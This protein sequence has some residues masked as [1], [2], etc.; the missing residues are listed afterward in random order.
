[1]KHALLAVPVLAAG[2]LVYIAAGASS[3]PPGLA[4][5]DGDRSGSASPTLRRVW[6]A[7]PWRT[8][9]MGTVS[10]DGRLLSFTDWNTGDV[11]VYDVENGE[12]AL[13]TG[14]PFVNGAGGF[15]EYS[16]VSRDG[17]QIAY[18]WYAGTEE[19]DEST[20]ELRIIPSDGSAPPRTVVAH[21]WLR[22]H[23]WSPDG[24]VV[25]AELSQPGRTSQIALVSV[26][27]GSVRRLRSLAWG[28]ATR[29]SFSPDGRYLAYAPVDP[30]GRSRTIYTLSIDASEEVPVV[31]GPDNATIAPR[32]SA[33][34]DYLI[35]WVPDGQALL[36]GSARAGTPGIWSVPVHK[37]RPT[38]DPR[39][40]RSDVWAAS[41]LGVTRDAEVFLATESSQ[42]GLFVADIEP[43]T[44]TLAGEPVRVQT[45]RRP[46]AKPPAWSRDGRSLAFIAAD[47][48]SLEIVHASTGEL[49]E[50]ASGLQ[51]VG[52]VTWLPDGMTLGLKG[53]DDSGRSGWFRL[54]PQTGILSPIAYQ[55]SYFENWSA[56]GKVVYYHHR[57]CLGASESESFFGV[58]AR[59][60][61]SGVDD[62]LWTASEPIPNGMLAGLDLSP[63]GRQLAVVGRNGGPVGLLS[64][65]GGPIRVLYRAG[66]D[67]KLRTA[68][69]AP[70]GEYL[71]LTVETQEG[72]G[73]WRLPAE[74]G[75]PELVEI[76]ENGLSQVAIHPTG[77][78]IAFTSGT[79]YQ[80]VWMLSLGGSEEGR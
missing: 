80:E 26:D 30:D 46:R 52:A 29:I 59:D 67:M 20:Y 38:G 2:W 11:G 56:D 41:G 10:S 61:A 37:G 18:S 9:S 36:F 22:P 76:I 15:A 72:K 34:E 44:G 51:Y 48:F 27:D 24:R 53:E 66:P 47:R 79:E 5:L 28:G 55:H 12:A 74:G 71:L 62:T 31:A 13:L 35:G 8:P 70:N 6:K 58:L 45:H 32:S 78:R 73:L 40:V 68:T 3:A 7:A 60:L 17:E 50:L 65:D 54:D 43:Q 42:M 63:D 57:C 75:E 39:L 16:A 25:V 49:R 33:E 23:D 1:M 77:R 64:V 21:P 69:W 14:S 4:E 19:A